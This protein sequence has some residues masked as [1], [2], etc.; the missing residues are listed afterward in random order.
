MAAQESRAKE[1]EKSEDSVKYHRKTRVR[2]GGLMV[3]A[4]YSRYSGYAP[5]R[6]YPGYWGPFW[7]YYSAWGW[8]DPWFYHPYY[9]SGFARGPN[10]G[11]VKLKAEPRQ[12]QVYIDG[13]Y[14]GQVSD[15]KS[16][17]LDPGAYNLEVKSEGKSF[18]R[19][20]YVLSGKTLRIDAEL[21]AQDREE[22]P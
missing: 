15:L 20:I 13:A 8:Y 11:E 6:F 10:M 1:P 7:P 2:F 9:Y 17:W 3:G 16:M 5:W 4:G 22:K 21:V 14:A 12:A 19:R 18:E